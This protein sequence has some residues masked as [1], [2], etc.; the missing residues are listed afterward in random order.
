[1]KFTL[2]VLFLLLAT[3]VSAAVPSARQVADLKSFIHGETVAPATKAPPPKVTAVV[4][5]AP[6]VTV[7]GPVE[8]F[9]R[10]LAEAVKAREGARMLPRLADRFT[11]ADLPEGHKASEFFVMGVNKIPGPTEMVV[12]S[13]ETKGP[14]R[15]AKVELRYPG[16]TKVKAFKFDDAGKL[17]GSDLFRLKRVNAGDDDSNR[18]G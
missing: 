11:I 3:A 8:D 2:P 14:A 1:M 9:L 13:V 4:S 6:G 12:L 7:D 16:N 18:H 17:L 15:L 10:A 5:T